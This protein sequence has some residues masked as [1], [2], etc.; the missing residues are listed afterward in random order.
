MVELRGLLL[1]S[2]ASS[3][4]CSPKYSS[5]H[6][7]GSV[8]HHISCFWV[9]IQIHV[10]Q[11][12]FKYVDKIYELILEPILSKKSSYKHVSANV[13]F[14]RY[15]QGVENEILWVFFISDAPIKRFFLVYVYGSFEVMKKNSQNW[16]LRPP[17]RFFF[18]QN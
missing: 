16:Y 10:V 11:G 15:I 14:P 18:C 7:D 8:F 12:V 3:Q 13:S 17:L 2:W 4:K 6:V 1:N 5:N 9:Y